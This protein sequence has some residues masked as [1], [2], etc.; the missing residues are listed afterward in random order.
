MGWRRSLRGEY[1][2]VLENISLLCSV[3]GC[4]RLSNEGECHEDE[5]TSALYCQRVCS[6]DP[7][8]VYRHSTC[9]IILKILWHESASE[10]YRPSDRRLSAKLLPTFA[11]TECHVVIATDPYTR[12][13]GFLDWSRYFFFQV[14]PQLYLRDWVDPVP[15]ALLL[16][17]CGSAGNRTR[18]SGSVARYSNY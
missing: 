13:F 11:D 17:K 18:T 1:H 12:I 4:S 9:F 15:D 16:R 6:I 2:A 5:D 7:K 3:T 10:L 14:A 8:S